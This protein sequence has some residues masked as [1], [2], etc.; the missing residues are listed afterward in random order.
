MMIDHYFTCGRSCYRIRHIINTFQC[1]EIQTAD[2]VCFGYQLI[3]K[4]FVTVVQE[5]V[6]AARHP[7]KEIGESI[8][9]DY[10]YCLFL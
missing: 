4:F 9:N 5:N 10:V 7:P 8:G 6:F 2:Y 1:I 3:R